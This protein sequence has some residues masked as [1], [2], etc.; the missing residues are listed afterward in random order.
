M[1]FNGGVDSSDDGDGG[2]GEFPCEWQTGDES[3]LPG[4]C[5]GMGLV[6]AS[7]LLGLGVGLAHGTGLGLTLSLGMGLHVAWV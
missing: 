1:G 2:E 5:L 7:A 3:V 6:W 4:L